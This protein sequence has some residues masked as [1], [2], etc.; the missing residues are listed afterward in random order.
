MRG[1][2]WSKEE[3]RE[4][5]NAVGAYSL[6]WIR[7]HTKAPYLFPGAPK[8]RSKGAI[9]QKVRRELGGGGLT[10]GSW[11]VA[12]AMAYTG[13]SRSQLF[14][15]QKALRQ[16]WQRLGP[17]GWYLITQEQ[18]E[19][20]TGWL[21]HDYWSAKLKLYGCVWCTTEVTPQRAAGL[22]ER[23]YWKH[24]RL[25]AR[26]KISPKIASQFVMISRRLESSPDAIGTRHGRFLERALSRLASGVA[27][28]R[29]DL[30]EVARLVE[31]SGAG[32]D[33]ED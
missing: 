31:D 26:L 15:A 23:C 22:C 10:R 33:D 16:R 2:P 21:L 28:E 17:K 4:L 8:Q 25:C 30:R 12:S 18:L 5:W 3:V 11:T 32:R 19:E 6:A 24:R 13:Y 14:R 20:L 29:A 9:Y 7:R 1:E 27:L